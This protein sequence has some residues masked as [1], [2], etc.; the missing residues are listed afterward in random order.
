ML[1]TRFHILD[2]VVDYFVVCEAEETHSGQPKP[3]NVL[4]NWDR[5]KPWHNKIIYV[6][7]GKLGN[8]NSWVRELNHRSKI[9]EGLTGAQDG[10]WIIV[11]D[12]DE[13]PHPDRAADL[14]NLSADGIKFELDLYYY[15]LNHRVSQGWAIGACRMMYGHDP[16][17]IRTQRGIHSATLHGGWHFSWF[18]G[19]QAILDKQ[20]AFM[21]FN[22]PIIR[23]MPR[24]PAWVAGRVTAGTDLFDRAGFVIERVPLTDTLPRYILDHIDEYRAKGW[25]E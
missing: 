25:C 3:L 16:N 13:I 17:T 15:D 20:A 10:D 6:N 7:A 23:D 24:D 12:V 9:S 8:Q 4:A 22:D 18:S 2:D 1:E 21:H 19:T 11:A 14:R 5:F